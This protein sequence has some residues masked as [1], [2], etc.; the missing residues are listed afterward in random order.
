MSHRSHQRSYPSG[1]HLGLKWEVVSNHFDGDTFRATLTITTLADREQLRWLCLA[2]FNPPEA[3]PDSVTGGVVMSVNGD[4]SA[5]ARRPPR[6]RARREPRDWP[7]GWLWAVV[8]TDA[9]LVLSS[10]TTTAGAGVGPSAI[11]NCAFSN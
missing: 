3:L 8:E 9:P 7:H 6:T 2:A 1:H 4:S 5:A 11:L 10:S